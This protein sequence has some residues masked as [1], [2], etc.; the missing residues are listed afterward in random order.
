MDSLFIINKILRKYVFEL[1]I[2]QI[3][4]KMSLNKLYGE[5]S[6]IWKM[7][8]YENGKYSNAEL[9]T[10]HY[11]ISILVMWKSDCGRILCPLSQTQNTIRKLCF[12]PVV[13]ICETAVSF[14]TKQS[15]EIKYSGVFFRLFQLQKAFKRTSFVYFD[16]MNHK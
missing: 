12:I 8:Y 9:L 13:V 5:I 10:V 14:Y 3:Y 1:F 4:F 6:E 2:S 11:F 16:T 7:K 15:S